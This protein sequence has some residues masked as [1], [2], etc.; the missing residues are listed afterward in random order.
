MGCQ[1][2]VIKPLLLSAQPIFICTSEGEKKTRE[3]GRSTFSLRHFLYERP[4]VPLVDP[5]SFP[6][7]LSPSFCASPAVRPYSACIRF[8]LRLPTITH[9]PPQTHLP[10]FVEQAAALRNK[11]VEEVACIS[12][13]DA[14]VMAAWGK[15]HSADGKV[16]HRVEV[17]VIRVDSALVFNKQCGCN[18]NGK[19]HGIFWHIS[20]TLTAGL[21]R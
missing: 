4:F 21:K 14:F 7:P 17:P 20:A 16:G 12:V 5:F 18:S 9:S 1:Q 8:Y 10:G 13:N 3:Q 6:L 2:E 15:E 11:G 19:L